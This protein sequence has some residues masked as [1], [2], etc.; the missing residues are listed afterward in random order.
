V[1]NGLRALSYRRRLKTSNNFI[2]VTKSRLPAGIDR[3]V[4]GVE[5]DGG[6]GDKFDSGQKIID[7]LI[8]NGYQRRGALFGVDSL[9]EAPQ[10]AFIPGLFQHRK[11][12]PVG[13][14]SLLWAVYTEF[15]GLK[16]RIESIYF[17]RLSQ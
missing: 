9:T 15:N 7:H 5:N 12:G 6:W 11:P 8:G 10:A 14:D 2:E 13:Q 17:V 1:K 4:S 16:Y 3:R